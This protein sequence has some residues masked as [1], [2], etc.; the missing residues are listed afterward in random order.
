MSEA[1]WPVIALFC[2]SFI[3]DISFVALGQEIWHD[4]EVCRSGSMGLS[5]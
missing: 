3:L 1:R 4:D 5:A 2:M